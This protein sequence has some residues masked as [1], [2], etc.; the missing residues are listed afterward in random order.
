MAEDRNIYGRA[1]AEAKAE[2]QS[3]RVEFD[4]LSKRKVQLEAFIANAEPL[5]PAPSEGPS[6]AF[7]VQEGPVHAF[8]EQKQ[9]T[10]LWKA[11]TLSI[12]GKR[13][14]F[15]VRDALDGLERI[16]HEVSSPNRFQIVRAV[17]IRKTEL[18]RKLDTPGM[19]AVIQPERK[20]AEEANDRF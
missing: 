2:L 14:G 5:I 15:T 13:D 3:L 12:N 17:L 9:K 4:R 6:L 19:Y 11:I 16:G 8:P 7:P 20:A 10:P 1:L 18:F